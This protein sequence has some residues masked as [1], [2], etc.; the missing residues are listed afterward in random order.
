MKIL[1]LDPQKETSHRISKETSGGYGTGKNVGDTL[2]NRLLK[3]TL[4]FLKF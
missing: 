4:N 2:V 1:L 3:K